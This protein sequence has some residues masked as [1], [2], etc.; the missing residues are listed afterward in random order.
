MPSPI[1]LQLYTIRE[2]LQQDFESTIKKVAAMGYIG[3]ETAAFWGT[4][5]QQ[6]AQLFRDLGLVV[7][8]AH[9]PL[10]LGDKQN[11]VLDIMALLGCQRLICAHFPPEQYQSINGIKQVCDILNEA[12]EVTLANGLSLGVHNHWWEFE[13]V[14]SGRYPYQ[15]WLERL[16]P[17]I[18]FEI[19]T[20]W[21]KTAG[22]DPGEIVTLF[23]AR[24][25][26]LHIKDGPATTSAPMV[27]L[28]EGVMDFPPL[29]DAATGSVEW[30]IVEL[31]HCATDMMKAVEASYR[32]LVEEG[33]A[34]G[35]KS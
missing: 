2:A 23:G 7:T 25:P 35:H 31:D 21:V 12:N 30:L 28:G 27:A 11:E 18:F 29:M 24:A 22:L 14:G 16:N 15:I 34:R 13:P 9:M 32:Y 19:D 5:P 10:P 33:F 20:Y 17:A 1:A 6:A 4:T 8:S 26:L 3:L